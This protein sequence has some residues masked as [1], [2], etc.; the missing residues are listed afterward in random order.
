M[1]SINFSAIEK[2]FPLNLHYNGNNSYLFVN[3]KE[4]IKSKAKNSEIVKD[5]ERFYLFKK[6]FKRRF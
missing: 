5:S 1:Y 4:I 6:H 2:R 3:G